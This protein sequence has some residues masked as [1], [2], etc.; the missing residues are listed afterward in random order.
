MRRLSFLKSAAPAVLAAFF[1]SR[2]LVFAVVL[3]ISHLE[4]A[5]ISFG[6]QVRETRINLGRDVGSLWDPFM[7][8]DAGWFRSIAE[9]GYARE[10]FH[11]REQRNWAFLP[12][13]PLLVRYLRILPEYAPNAILWSNLLFLAALFALHGATRATGLSET[14]A[15]RAVALVAFFPTSY[16][17]FVPGSESLY[18]LAAAGAWW[19]AARERWGVAG[20]VACLAAATRVTGILLLPALLILFLQSHRRPDRRAA[21][22]LV[23]PLGLGAFMLFLWRTTGNPLAFVEI[24]SLWHRGTTSPLAPYLQFFRDL[25]MVSVEWNLRI[26]HAAAGLL[27][28]VATGM[29][30]LRRRYALAFFLVGTLAVALSSGSLQ[31]LTRYAATAFPLFMAMG[32]AIDDESIAAPILCVSAAL[33][34]VLTCLFAMRIDI[35]MS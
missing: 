5:K 6:G 30:A 18:L 31:S 35:G 34:G 22:L 11:T 27:M 8:A 10:A 19:A 9:D 29:L 7:V 17:F 25:P 2:L 26:L 15:R 32:D 13:F 12:A 3:L 24:Q 33:L 16:F 4:T 21:W 28:L 14:A 20:A 23:V 1:A